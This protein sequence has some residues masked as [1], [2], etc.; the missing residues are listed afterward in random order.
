M[1]DPAANIAE[2]LT[3]LDRNLAVLVSLLAAHYPALRDSEFSHRTTI[4][5]DLP[6]G[7]TQWPVSQLDAGLFER[8][9]LNCDALP[10][11]TAFQRDVIV[12]NQ[13]RALWEARPRVFCPATF[14]DDDGE[15]LLGCVRE[16]HAHGNHEDPTGR[17]WWIQPVGGGG[18]AP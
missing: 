9:E 6:T 5:V 11:Q 2:S 12:H 14:E 16:F 18:V 7:R 8:L 1:T 10:E 13:V 4:V 15:V 3:A 17:D